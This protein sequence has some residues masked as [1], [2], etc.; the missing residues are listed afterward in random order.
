MYNR[1][2]PFLYK[3][4]S[5][6]KC[7]YYICTLLILFFLS[8]SS[9]SS[10]FFFLSHNLYFLFVF[11]FFSS[12]FVQLKRCKDLVFSSMFQIEIRDSNCCLTC[13]YSARPNP[14]GPSFTQLN[15]EQGLVWVIKKKKKKKPKAGPSFIKNPTRNPDLTR[16]L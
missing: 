3:N 15:K 5:W 10:S 8:S 6:C 12:S 11:F 1:K 16:L 4:R 9:S 14:N 7:S 2:S 13:R